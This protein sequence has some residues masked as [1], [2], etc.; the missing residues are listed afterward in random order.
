MLVWSEAEERFFNKMYYLLCEQWLLTSTEWEQP[1][2]ELVAKM[3]NTRFLNVYEY[4]RCDN[5][6]H[7][8]PQALLTS[9]IN[10]L[11]ACNSQLL[12]YTYQYHEPYFSIINTWCTFVENTKQGP[13][14]NSF[15]ITLIS[16]NVRKHSTTNGIINSA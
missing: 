3:V 4:R 5:N 12:I 8:I 9:K 2:N 13:F 11:M 14:F 16:L 6:S 7:F 10:L 1:P 15:Q